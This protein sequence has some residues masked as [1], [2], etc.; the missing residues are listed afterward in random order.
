MI[1]LILGNIGENFYL[2]PT[3][4]SPVKLWVDDFDGNGTV[5][6]MI[7]YTVGGRDMPVFLKREITDQFPALK[8][9]NLRHAEYARK[10]IQD[11]FTS[12]IL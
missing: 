10:S 8:K 1:D 12:S 4:K 3:E 6:Q 11:H 7:T 5:E 9:G 2:R